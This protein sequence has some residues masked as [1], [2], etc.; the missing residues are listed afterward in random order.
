MSAS[1][2]TPSDPCF[3]IFIPL[4]NT[5]FLNMGWTYWLASNEQNTVEMIECHET[6]YVMRRPWLL[7]CVFSLAFSLITCL[8]GIQLPYH[9]WP[10]W[11]TSRAKYWKS[12]NS[13]VSKADLLPPCEKPW[14]RGTQ[15]SHTQIPDPQKLYDNKCLLF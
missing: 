15:L 2:I 11:E 9:E 4:C 13:H 10:C 8:E 14:F 12:A 5:V 6:F 1:K 7:S 3:L